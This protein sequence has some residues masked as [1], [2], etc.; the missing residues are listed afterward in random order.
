[1]IDT[2]KLKLTA[3]DVRAA[4]RVRHP[5][6]EW[7]LMFEVSDAAGFGRG[8]SADA[9]AMNLWPSRGLE[10]H[11]FEIKVSRADWKRELV[12]PEKSASIQRYCDRWWIAAPRDLVPADELPRTWGL[13]EIDGAGKA[14]V[15]VDAPKLPAEPMTRSFVACVL[16]RASEADAGEVE[17]LV[18][19]KVAELHA[20]NDR[21]VAQEVERK[22]RHMDAAAKRIAEI[23]AECGIDLLDFRPN[24]ELSKALR[25]VLD[26][27]LFSSYQGLSNALRDVSSLQ[28]S[29]TSV[30][31]ALG[32]N[33]E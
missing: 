9:L 13:M 21:R 1:M 25:A 22:T 11:G 4:L 32:I 23:K 7:A 26:G 27:H 8:R 18:S 16:R 15:K 6:S 28:A 24:G 19:R 10:L 17:A 31:D 30:V 20:E 2:G 33:R 3:G 29:L 14:V 5:K 12:N